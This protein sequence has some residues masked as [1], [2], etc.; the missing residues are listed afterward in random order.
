MKYYNLL[1]TTDKEAIKYDEVCEEF[2]S[3]LMVQ[4]YYMIKFLE[5]LLV[6]LNAP[7]NLR[8]SISNNLNNKAYILEIVNLIKNYG[9]DNYKNFVD[10][11]NNKLE[12]DRSNGLLMKP[13]EI[14]NN[15]HNKNMNK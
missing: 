9:I 6:V 10:Y 11:Y 12:M 5:K 2:N 7:G 13:S 3:S 1:T 8:M 4:D 15:T 14:V